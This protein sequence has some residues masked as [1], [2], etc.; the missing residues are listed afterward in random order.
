MIGRQVRAGLVM[1]NGGGGAPT[2]FGPYG[3]YKESGQGREYGRFAFDE[4]TEVKH[5]I[6]PAGR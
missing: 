1:I 4:F 2:P 5:M 3:G 6:W